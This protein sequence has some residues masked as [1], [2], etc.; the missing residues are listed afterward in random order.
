MQKHVGKF[1]FKDFG[2]L[3]RAE[4]TI[5]TTSFGVGKDNPI[6]ELLQTPFAVFGTQ[7]PA[8]IFRGDDCRR[9]HTPKIGV[10][11]TT[12][13]EDYFTSFPVV[14][15]DVAS[16]PTYVVIRVDALCG[17]K[18][19]QFKSWRANRVVDEILF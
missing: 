16:L 5:V 2:I 19:D 3:V 13:L 17:E 10:F 15:N 8:K 14:L 12:L 18:T 1:V 9:I 7:G 4:V 6:N 11:N